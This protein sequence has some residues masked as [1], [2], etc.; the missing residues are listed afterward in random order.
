MKPV[1]CCLISLPLC[2]TKHSFAQRLQRWL[3]QWQVKAHVQFNQYDPT[4]FAQLIKSEQ[5]AL[6][7]TSG[8]SVIYHALGAGW[9]ISYQEHHLSPDLVHVLLHCR[10]TKGEARH[11]AVGL[12]F[13]F[14]QWQTE[15]YVIM[16]AAV[17]NG[18]RFE[19]RSVNYSPKL[20]YYARFYRTAADSL[21][22]VPADIGKH[23]PPIIS[24]VPRLEIGEGVSWIQFRSGDMS[25]PAIGIFSPA[26][27]RACWLMTLQ[28]TSLGDTGISIEESKDRRR[29]W[30][31]F[32]V[33]V[34]RQRYRY[35]I[36]TTRAP[37]LDTAFHFT[38]G[39]AFTLSIWLHDS[40]AEHLQKLFHQFALL[41]KL[42]FPP[43]SYQPSLPFS[44]AAHWMSQH[45]NHEGWDPT[46]GFY[47][48]GSWRR[49]SP[50]WTGGF[51][52][53]YAMLLNQPEDTTTYRRVLRELQFA[54]TKGISPSGFFWEAYS[55]GMPTAGDYRRP[56][57]RRWHLVRKSAD[58]LYYALR[59]LDYLNR[60]KPYWRKDFAEVTQ[61]ESNLQG[62]AEAFVRNWQKEKQLGQFT[63]AY[64]GEIIVGG[65]ASGALVPAGLVLA[66]Q[67][68]NKPAYL[69]VASEVMTYYD[70]AFIQKGYCTGGP[71]DA[72]QNPDSESTY[73][74]LESAIALYQATKNTK[75]LQLAEQV[76]LQFA[77][78]VMPY[79][80]QFPPHSTFGKL[81]IRTTG[82]VW[83]NTQN[84]HGA[85]NICTHSGLALLKLYHYTRNP[86]Y[87]ELL[88]DIAFH[89]VQYISRKGHLIAN[90]PQ[91]A[92][93]ERCNTTDWL[94]GIGEVF[95][96]NTW[97]QIANL[98]TTGQLPGLYIDATGKSFSFD[99]IEA[100]LIATKKNAWTFELYNPT[101]FEAKVKIFV[102]NQAASLD[103][104]EKFRLVTIPPHTRQTIVIPKR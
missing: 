97:A 57:T 38:E 73:A 49:W 85:P 100:H 47:S 78:W 7:S 81:K 28:G 68:F 26:Q 19:S 71:G 32:T 56:H 11:A 94:E 33:P 14:N 41:R 83:A 31:S 22:D 74:L 98:L 95:S 2:W 76:A 10:V 24:D 37:S 21:K 72:M 16:P 61:W 62:V 20:P 53:G 70:T 84:K 60:T 92:V 63:D 42:P 23:V 75:W 77:T 102:E 34:V 86:F 3:D 8:D 25:S 82:A 51:Q 29:A 44:M 13:E 80:Y 5:A 43:T 93:N 101:E 79:D 52:I 58:G 91:G 1:I 27:R 64:T 50:G 48:V 6:P 17:Y 88:K 46:Q 65:S 30:I 66:S 35:T 69:A 4:R 89:S 18:N 40:P 99:H 39:T 90:L 104:P 67:Y 54:L 103:Q 9:Q 15:N 55:Q 96:E 36:T 59:L 87:A 12:V 45:M